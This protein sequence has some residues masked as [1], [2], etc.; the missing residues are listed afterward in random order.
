MC[1]RATSA[2]RTL[3]VGGRLVHQF[4]NE[5]CTF[6][7]KQ[8][9][10]GRSQDLGLQVETHKLCSKLNDETV[11]L[12]RN[13]L[14]SLTEHGGHSAQPTQYLPTGEYA[15]FGIREIGHYAIPRTYI[16]LG[17]GTVPYAPEPARFSGARP[18]ARR[19]S[20]ARARALS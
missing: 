13:V 11:T 17:Q 9:I 3:S 16:A 14:S 20:Y 2:R 18:A 8:T 5:V 4:P 10:T 6:A 1:V 7:R 15:S 12:T 19:V